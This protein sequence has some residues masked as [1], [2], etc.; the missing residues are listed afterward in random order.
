MYTRYGEYLV[1]FRESE[2]DD[3]LLDARGRGG[4]VAWGVSV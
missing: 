4:G 1:K 2:S 3:E